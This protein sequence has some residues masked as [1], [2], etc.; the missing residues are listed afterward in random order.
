M[1]DQCGI[2]I[3]SEKLTPK[4]SNYFFISTKLLLSM[5]KHTLNIDSTFEKTVRELKSNITKELARFDCNVIDTNILHISGEEH[6]YT[7]KNANTWV[8]NGK[9]YSESELIEILTALV[10]SQWYMADIVL[11]K[12]E[13]KGYKTV[14]VKQKKMLGRFHSML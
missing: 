9:S 3:F 12:T 13:L 4:Y 10:L 7:R 11:K 5:K 8:E 2:V 14:A 1:I 6:H